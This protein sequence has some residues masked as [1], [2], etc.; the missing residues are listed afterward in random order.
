[1][2]HTLSFILYLTNKLYLYPMIIRDK[3]FFYWMQL[4]ENNQCYSVF[5][6]L[7]YYMV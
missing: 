6:L 2:P 1:M 3:T 5:I 4:V 7:S